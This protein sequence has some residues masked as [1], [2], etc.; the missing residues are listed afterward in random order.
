MKD[1]RP[2]PPAPPLGEAEVLF[3][4]L[5]PDAPLSKIQQLQIRSRY[6]RPSL[7]GEHPWNVHRGYLLSEAKRRGI[8]RP[9]HALD[10]VEAYCFEL[11]LDERFAAVRARQQQR[12]T[13]AWSRQWGLRT[14]GLESDDDPGA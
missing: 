1:R 13:V 7:V 3:A 12:D 8:E 2:T 11:L 14:D 10:G 5:G 4:L 9:L 6:V